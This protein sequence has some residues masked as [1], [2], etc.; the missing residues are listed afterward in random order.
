GVENEKE[1]QDVKQPPPVLQVEPV[2][3]QHA[4]CH[5]DEIT[6]RQRIAA[7]AGSGRAPRKK[8]CEQRKYG[9]PGP[10]QP[11][12]QYERQRRHSVL[13]ES[14]EERSRRPHTGEPVFGGPTRLSE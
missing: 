11:V 8:H 7:L 9:K 14:V 10:V 12:W 2:Q 3:A 4:S 5:Q 6:E 1:N 13:Q